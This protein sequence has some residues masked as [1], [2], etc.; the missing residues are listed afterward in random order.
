MTDSCNK[1]TIKSNSE[2]KQLFE[3][4]KNAVN[5]LNDIKTGKSEAKD[6]NDLLK[7]IN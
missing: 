1:K 6:F 7:E 5:E 2:N 3:K 4:I